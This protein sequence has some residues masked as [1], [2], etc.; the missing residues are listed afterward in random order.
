MSSSHFN[1]VSAAMNVKVEHVF[2]SSAFRRERAEYVPHTTEEAFRHVSFNEC[3]VGLSV[4]FRQIVFSNP[5]N[6]VRKVNSQ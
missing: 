3:G 4:Q 6:P 5:H 2:C 1:L